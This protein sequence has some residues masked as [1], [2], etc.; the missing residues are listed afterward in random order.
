MELEQEHQQQ[1][2]QEEPMA[3]R[4]TEM[5]KSEV[6]SLGILVQSEAYFS[7]RDDGFNGGRKFG[8]GPVRIDMRGVVDRQ[9]TYRV[10]ADFTRQPVILDAQVGYLISGSMRVIA[11]AF[12]PVLSRDLD[13]SPGDTDFM[14]R[15]RQVGAM[16]NSR[17]I[18][19]T[20]LGEPGNMN[21]RIGIYNGTGLTGVN[22]NRFLYTARAGYAT[23]VDGTSLEFGLIG[24]FDQTRGFRVG[25]TGL[26]SLGD[27]KLYGGFA[28]FDSGR[29]FGTFEFLQT[30]FD[31]LQYA[32]AEETITGFYGTF[33]GRVN[34][35]SE[36]LIRWDHLSFDLTDS[37]SELITLGWNYQATRLISFTWNLLMQHN[38][39]GDD[40]FGV[41]GQIQF[42]F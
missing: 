21:Y 32:G 23:D 31:A 6:F 29:F 38:E 28:G 36:L 2:V 9:F 41:S 26:N 20:L 17:E 7:A 13:P 14:N 33:G 16:M 1:N 5:F 11:G 42:Q 8:T 18:G 39:G 35:K 34:P 37:S 4:L 25:N 27:R 10:Q 24:A 22:D 30:R 15:A 40:Q 19:V 3:D 12:K